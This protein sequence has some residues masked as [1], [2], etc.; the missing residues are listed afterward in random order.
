MDDRTWERMKVCARARCRWMYYDSSRNASSK[1]CATEICGS[2]EKARRAH[3]RKK[4]AE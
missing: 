1:W 2:L 3:Q 4:L